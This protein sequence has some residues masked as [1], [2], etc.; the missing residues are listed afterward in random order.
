MKK[1]IIISSIIPIIIYSAFSLV[2]DGNFTNIPQI[3]TLALGNI[4]IILGVLSMFT[5]YF[6]TSL[7]LKDSLQMDHRHH[8]MTAWFLAICLPFIIFLGVV[9]Y[10][11]LQFVDILGIGGIVLGGIYGIMTLIMVHKAK[12][13]G[14]R[15]PEFSTISNW[16]ISTAIT[17]LFI[18]GIVWTIMEVV[19]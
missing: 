18:A 19:G 10:G 4:F 8:P 11:F 5:A 3:A 6:S 17:L 9:N 2:V 16:A 1:S 12:K 7:T 15:K 14:D 13:Y